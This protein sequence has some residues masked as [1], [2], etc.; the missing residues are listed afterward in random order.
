MVSLII[1]SLLAKTD[2]L[3]EELSNGQTVRSQCGVNHGG[4]NKRGEARFARFVYFTTYDMQFKVVVRIENILDKIQYIHSCTE[5]PRISARDGGPLAPAKARLP[6][7]QRSRPRPLSR[8]LALWH[9]RISG[10]ELK[11][12][13]DRIPPRAV[14]VDAEQQLG[15]WGRKVRRRAA[16][17][18]ARATTG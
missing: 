5:S 2:T 12:Q 10:L 13:L 9:S 6:L 4:R 1:L 18:R 7:A 14:V 17:T 15:T 11:A 16:S 8:T 3:H